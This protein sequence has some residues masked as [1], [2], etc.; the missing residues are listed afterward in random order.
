MAIL[1]KVW[2]VWALISPRPTR[3][4]FL[5]IRRRPRSTQL[6][7]LFPYTTLFRSGQ[8]R[9]PRDSEAHEGH[10]RGRVGLRLVDVLDVDREGVE[11]RQVRDRVLAH[12][13][14]E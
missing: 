9:R 12:H 5:M 6:R 10:R 13:D 7:T 1:A 11:R 3:F 14:R 4:L 8:H 2:A